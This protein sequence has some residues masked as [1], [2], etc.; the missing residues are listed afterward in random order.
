MGCGDNVADGHGRTSIRDATSCWEPTGSHIADQP[1]LDDAIARADVGL[2]VRDVLAVRDREVAG[3]H[4]GRRVVELRLEWWVFVHAQVPR[5]GAARVE[6]AATRW[7]DRR[8]HVAPEP[9]ESP[10]TGTRGPAWAALA[11]ALILAERTGDAPGGDL[12]VE[13]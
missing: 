7:S 9:L 5:L 1:F 12:R 13:F 11:A 10:S 4:M 6:P 2:G 3:R 8:R